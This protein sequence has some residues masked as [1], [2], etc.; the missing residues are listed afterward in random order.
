MMVGRMA[1]HALLA[2][3]LQELHVVVRPDDPLS[4]LSSPSIES[5]H[6]SR[7]QLEIIVCADAYKGMSYSIRSGVDAILSSNPNVDAIV[8][9]LGDQPFIT[10]EMVRRLI[11]LMKENAEI[12]Y[13][14]SSN[15]GVVMPPAILAK[16][17][18]P[19]LLKLEGDAGARKLLLSADYRGMIVN[20]EG[21]DSQLLLDVDDEISLADARD[22]YYKSKGKRLTS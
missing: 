8:I 20:Y 5:E 17:M 15:K 6:L 4:W 2:N 12:D 9:A 10:A 19:A 13:A 18:F 11:M 3:D 22:Y 7:S 21:N 16:T 14:A 1:L